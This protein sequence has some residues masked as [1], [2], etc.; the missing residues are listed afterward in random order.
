MKLEDPQ[1]LELLAQ[2]YVLGTQRG[3]ARRRFAVLIDQRSDVRQA[4]DKWEQRLTPL[5]WNL[6][7]IAPSDLLWQRLS[8]AL[9]LDNKAPKRPLPGADPGLWRGIAAMLAFVVIFMAGGWWTAERRGPEIVRETVIEQ[10]PEQVAVALFADEG[11]EPLWVT[12][13]ATTSGELAVRVVGDITAQPANDYQLWALTDAGIPVSL[14]LLPQSG[15]LTLALD[16]A[17]R[18]A[19]QSSSTLAVSLEPPGGSPEPVPTGPVLY[20]AALLAS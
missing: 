18:A 5:V 11:G 3:G 19:L 16:S 15:S 12:R 7:P 9:G 17:A 10:V 13:I 6:A 4:V 14:G 8:R 20:T 1:L 2:R